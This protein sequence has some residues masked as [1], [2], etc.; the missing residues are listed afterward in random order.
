[1]SRLKE[2]ELPF[3]PSDLEQMVGKEF[4]I[5]ISG[6]RPLDVIKGKKEKPQPKRVQLKRALAK[7]HYVEEDEVDGVVSEIISRRPGAV[8]NYLFGDAVRV[9][10]EQDDRIC[11]AIRDTCSEFVFVLHSVTRR[12]GYTLLSGMSQSYNLSDNSVGRERLMRIELQPYAYKRRGT[13]I[14]PTSGQ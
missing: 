5:L 9:T 4:Y 1:M 14:C 2:E 3:S 11:Y 7:R 13:I 6:K 12:N 10:N 8:E